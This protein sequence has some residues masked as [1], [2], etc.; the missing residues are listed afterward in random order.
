[1]ERGL[2]VTYDRQEMAF[3]AAMSDA[4]AV[5][6]RTQ[7]L[8]LGI[9]AL[10]LAAGVA[11]A[12]GVWR[13]VSANMA[14]AYGLVEEGQARLQLAL[15]AAHMA[16][17]DWDSAPIGSRGRVEQSDSSTYRPVLLGGLWLSCSSSCIPRIGLALEAS[18]RHAATSG[19][20]HEHEFRVVWPDSS[21]RWIV[22]RSRSTA[23]QV[24]RLGA[25]AVGV[26]L[27]ISARKIAELELARLGIHGCAHWT[28][29]PSGTDR[30]TGVGVRGRGCS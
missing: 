10:V 9:S 27:D 6:Q 5:Q 25:P 20:K 29:Q 30:P 13:T 18:L 8:L 2:K 12:I 3:F 11:L 24:D 26:Y 1:M 15:D 14:R 19:G 23:I 21:I 7:L 4:L 17:W 16:T 28:T 22:A